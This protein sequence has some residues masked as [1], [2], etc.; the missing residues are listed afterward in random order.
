V[1]W[2]KKI[3]IWPL[4]FGAESWRLS[5]FFSI[6]LLWMLRRTWSRDPWEVVEFFSLNLSG[7]SSVLSSRL[8]KK[9][10]KTNCFLDLQLLAPKVGG[11]TIKYFTNSQENKSSKACRF[12]IYNFSFYCYIIPIIS[13]CCKALHRFHLHR[14][15]KLFQVFLFFVYKLWISINFWSYVVFFFFGLQPRQKNLPC[16]KKLC[17]FICL[18]IYC[19]LQVPPSSKV[20]S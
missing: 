8:H 9:Q 20:L 15:F 17:I 7:K 1:D 10:S 13:L 5:I 4:T 16:P 3:C 11:R 19:F 2:S 6:G 18:L 14:Y 12:R